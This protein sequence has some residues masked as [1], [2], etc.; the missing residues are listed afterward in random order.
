L[1][2]VGHETV[3]LVPSVGLLHVFEQLLLLLRRRRLLLE[4]EEEEQYQLYS[5]SSLTIGQNVVVG[6][7][8]TLAPLNFIVT[9][10]PLDVSV[11]LSITPY[12]LFI[13]LSSSFVA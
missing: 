2:Q 11:G 5:T 13:V 8:A 9:F 10:E 1:H 7:V 3:E 4:L 12:T 6:L